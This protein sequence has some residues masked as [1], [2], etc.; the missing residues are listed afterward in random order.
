LAYYFNNEST[1]SFLFYIWR[2]LTAVAASSFL[3]PYKNNQSP[4]NIATWYWWVGR[5]CW[6]S[7]RNGT[8]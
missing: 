6:N 3:Y 2:Y 1:F 8:L 5:L 4:A 7:K